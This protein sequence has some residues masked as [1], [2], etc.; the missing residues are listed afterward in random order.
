MLKLRYQAKFKRDY[1]KISKRGCDVKFLKQVL[2]L[3]CHEQT[4]PPKYRDHELIGIYK[5]YRECH[6]NPDW[7]LIYRID[8][9]ILTLSLIRTGT[10][11]DLF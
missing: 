2:E 7:L 1:K 3:L 5:G 11:S 4:L 8:S 10:H 6:I 9:D